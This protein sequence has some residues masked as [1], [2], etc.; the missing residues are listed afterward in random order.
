M[1]RG[2]L[3]MA[4]VYTARVQACRAAAKVTADMLYLHGSNGI[5]TEYPVEKLWRDAQ[6]LRFADGTTD[7]VS[8]QAAPSWSPGASWGF[9]QP[10]DAVRFGVVK[11]VLTS[12]ARLDS[13]YDKTDE[14]T[15]AM[16]WP[17][18]RLRWSSGTW[19]P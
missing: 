8:M 4:A 3:D 16:A 11:E 7:V 6:P 19:R 17:T 5:T 13:A 14:K 2:N 10:R 12:R 15:E 9:H 18:M 1:S